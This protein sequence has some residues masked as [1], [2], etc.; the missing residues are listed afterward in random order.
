MHINYGLVIIKQTKA[1][2]KLQTF[3][4]HLAPIQ[5]ESGRA[6]AVLINSVLASKLMIKKAVAATEN[7]NCKVDTVVRCL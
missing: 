4:F 1:N 3:S 5:Y 2:N 7:V 6:S